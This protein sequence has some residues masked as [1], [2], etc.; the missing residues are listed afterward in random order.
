[1]CPP[2]S[3]L[4]TLPTGLSQDVPCGS[5]PARSLRPLPAAIGPSQ[6]FAL[7]A[8]CPTAPL[9]GVDPCAPLPTAIAKPLADVALLD[10]VLRFQKGTLPPSRSSWGEGPSFSSIP[11]WVPLSSSLGKGRGG[12]SLCLKSW[13]DS[14][15]WEAGVPEARADV[16]KGPLSMVLQD[17]SEVVFLEN[18]SFEEEAPFDKELSNFKDFSRYLGMPVEG[19]EEKIV[20]LLKKLKKM[21]G[22]GTLCKKRKKEVVSTSRSEREL[23]RLDCSVSYGEPANRRSGKS[24]WELIPVD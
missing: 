11:S 18:A 23:K 10:K 9:H 3:I 14:L 1:M 17:G 16:I 22:G 21:T 4:L 5:L 12:P 2:T 15:E 24:K 13:G 20:L 19:Y 7:S 8:S 6:G